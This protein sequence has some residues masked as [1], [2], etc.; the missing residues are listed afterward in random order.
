V[1]VGRSL[2]WSLVTERALA[3]PMKHR[4]CPPGHARAGRARAGRRP[5]TDG[6]DPAKTADAVRSRVVTCDR[7]CHED[8]AKTAD[9]VR[10]RVVTRDR[11]RHED[12]AKAADAV[13]SRVVTRDRERHEDLPCGGSHRRGSGPRYFFGTAWATR[14]TGRMVDFQSWPMRSAMARASRSST[15]VPAI[16][17]AL[18]GWR[19]LL[20]TSH[21][22]PCASVSPV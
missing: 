1:V 21:T 10:S 8:P 20:A 18:P 13:R 3:A 11:E 2:R 16:E 17:Y 5:R 6:G 14:K 4:S 12:P 9:A 22:V 15:N 19:R 7:E